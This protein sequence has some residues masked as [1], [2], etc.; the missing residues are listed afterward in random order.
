M[1][2]KDFSEFYVLMI[3]FLYATIPQ[4]EQPQTWGELAT[5]S[6]KPRLEKKDVS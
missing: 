2:K 5:I 1:S 4:P 6:N 3:F